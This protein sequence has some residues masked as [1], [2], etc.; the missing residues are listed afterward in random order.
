MVTNATIAT[1]KSNQENV[2]IG[3]FAVF[4]TSIFACFKSSSNSLLVNTCLQC[5]H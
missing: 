4:V 3:V 2:Q 5:V 1:A